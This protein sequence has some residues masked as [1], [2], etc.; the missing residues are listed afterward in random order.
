MVNDVELLNAIKADMG[1]EGK[2]IGKRKYV[3]SGKL[4]KP[5]MTKKEKHAK[6]MLEGGFGFKDLL[7]IPAT[8]AKIMFPP[9]AIALKAV[10]LGKGK[11]GTHKQMNQK[12][13]DGFLD[14][15]KMP[16]KLIGMGADGEPVEIPLEYAEKI[17]GSGMTGG[18]AFLKFL[19]NLKSGYTMPR[20]MW[21]LYKDLKPIA[22]KGYTASG[23]TAAGV[24]AA[25]QTAG[26]RKYVKKAKGQTGGGETGGSFLDMASRIAN[27]SPFTSMSADVAPLSHI[28]PKDLIRDVSVGLV[29]K[30]MGKGKKVKKEKKP[31]RAVSPKVAS[32]AALV[33][34]IMKEKGFS[35][36]E[37]S[38]Y[39]KAKGLKY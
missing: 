8:A 25:G 5:R 30:M 18:N 6:E 24:T 1:L 38:K 29:E 22:G 16:L 19:E 27:F 2:G 33:K 28:I 21:K 20:S 11:K 15:L 7:R 39:V 10:G 9:A 12:H 3:K 32:R 35:V 14:I 37:A 17:V 23:V 36:I 26:K 4:R 13:G 31:K 34:K